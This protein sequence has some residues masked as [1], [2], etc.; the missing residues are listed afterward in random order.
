MPK[1]TTKV[2][3]RSKSPSSKKYSLR[4]ADASIASNDHFNILEILLLDH[5]YFKDCIDVL[6]DDDEDP[7]V[8]LK[9]AKGFLDALEK[10]SHGEKKA[11]YTPLQEVKELRSQIL[12]SIIEHAIVD[13]KVKQLSKKLYKSKNLNEDMQA[14]LKVLAG[15]VEHHIE[16][17][18]DGLFPKMRK[19]I[20]PE[21]LNQ[22]GYQF[23]VLR[24]FSEKDLQD[25]PDLQG[26][27]EHVSQLAIPV[28]NF[29]NVTHEY[30]SREY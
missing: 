15:L 19:D 11:L 2:S 6:K 29:L 30:F 5:S 23:M 25:S 24:Q 22:M 9:Y 3:S 18:E 21:I 8:K 12:E 10:H 26:E 1:T 17:E 16:E 28:K 4:T 7:E 14:E 13:E 20:D 27:L